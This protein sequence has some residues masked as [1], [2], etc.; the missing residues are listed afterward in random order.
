MNSQEYDETI[1]EIDDDV[2]D[3]VYAMIALVCEV[4][5]QQ[6]FFIDDHTDHEGLGEASSRLLD[7][8]K[9][10][11]VSVAS[12][13]SERSDLRLTTAAIVWNIIQAVS[14]TFSR[15]GLH[16]Q[17]EVISTNC[18]VVDELDPCLPNSAILET[19]TSVSKTKQDEDA[20]DFPQFLSH[21]PKS[22]FQGHE[23][24]TESLKET[25]LLSNHKLLS[26]SSSDNKFASLP[27]SGNEENLVPERLKETLPSVNQKPSSLRFNATES[28]YK[29]PSLSLSGN[30]DNLMLEH[31]TTNSF[32]N[33]SAVHEKA[34]QTSLKMR[35]VCENDLTIP[36]I[37]D[38]LLDIATSAKSPQPNHNF[39]QA[40]FV[41][42]DLLKMA[43]TIR[44]SCFENE[45]DVN[46]LFSGLSL[47][48]ILC[49]HENIFVKSIYDYFIGMGCKP[50]QAC[51]N[52][53][54]VYA[55]AACQGN[56]E[57]MKYIRDTHSNIWSSTL[58][59]SQNTDRNVLHCIMDYAI[60]SNYDSLFECL[61]PS[62]CSE[63]CKAIKG[64]IVP[65]LVMALK[66]GNYA[67]IQSISKQI[68]IWN[69][70]TANVADERT[71]LFM[72]MTSPHAHVC[73]LQMIP[74]ITSLESFV[75]QSNERPR[76]FAMMLQSY[77]M[78][79]RNI[80]FH[81]LKQQHVLYFMELDKVE[82]FIFHDK[83]TTRSGLIS[84]LSFLLE[85]HHSN[86]VVLWHC[87][88]LVIGLSHDEEMALDLL[89]IANIEAVKNHHHWRSFDRFTGES[90][91]HIAA[92]KGWTEILSCLYDLG[93]DINPFCFM[94]QT[95][96]HSCALHNSVK[97]IML[98]NKLGAEASIESGDGI[99]PI[100]CSLEA[101]N[102]ECSMEILNNVGCKKSLFRTDS[103]GLSPLMRALELKHLQVAHKI[104]KMFPE[105]ANFVSMSGTNI[106]HAAAPHLA[107]VQQLVSWSSQEGKDIW[108][109]L[110]QKNN[111]GE[112]PKD[113][114]AHCGYLDSLRFFMQI[115]QAK[116]S[117]NAVKSV[118]EMDVQYS[119]SKEAF[120]QVDFSSSVSVHRFLSNHSDSIDSYDFY[121]R[122]PIILAVQAKNLLGA[123]HLV[124][125]GADILKTDALGNSVM[126]Y[127]FLTNR[128]QSLWMW[129][130][131]TT[132]DTDPSD[133]LQCIIQRNSEDIVAKCLTLKNNAGITPFGLA[134]MNEFYI[135]VALLCG[136]AKFPKSLLNIQLPN[137]TY[138]LHVACSKN[139]VNLVVIFLNLGSNP[140]VFDSN[141]MSPEYIARSH[142]H[143][144]ITLI[145]MQFCNALKI[146]CAVRGYLCRVHALT[147]RAD[148]I[149]IQNV[150]FSIIEDTTSSM[151]QYSDLRV[152]FPRAN[153]N[154]LEHPKHPDIVP[155]AYAAMYDLIYVFQQFNLLVNVFLYSGV[156]TAKH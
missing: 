105:Q 103:K 147:N 95:P 85:K 18:I 70:T 8:L 76:E 54:N 56:F 68:Y 122:T 127:M 84:R 116:G 141:G 119:E 24:S 131:S 124:D 2:W 120:S 50:D 53:C 47:L 16:I 110:Q 128:E 11:D 142:G 100:A 94:M 108:A 64:D 146:Q 144:S 49:I 89:S 93:H 34:R 25:L 40:N 58:C 42:G 137:G 112:T 78:G 41:H 149:G 140:S 15:P 135:D 96:M 30:Q 145:L 32:S 36:V 154:A 107:S 87:I 10:Y 151:Q 38:F 148:C 77:Q 29:F 73:L 152:N 20:L 115:Y 12:S 21:Q 126:H 66:L 22:A 102:I 27:S 153:W 111:G 3:V 132:S 6:Y 143:N 7:D 72:M 91:L 37:T 4:N 130:E 55:F 35:F 113:I 71:F 121:H 5:G 48:H 90:A 75:V 28:E 82:P 44:F 86:T 31:T 117:V 13:D 123:Q 92:K 74:N 9:E 79:H 46:R 39:S 97:C 114:A 51:S 65:P 150:V 69:L 101:M 45:K 59:R 43:S 104:L 81:I 156:I 138:C 23:S 67:F 133:V 155:M 83:K 88:H 136:E 19:G 1:I 109:F 60:P 63:M 17:E 134:V 52:G 125:A 129:E 99:S 118:Q 80:V 26:S 98:L 33:N 14:E 139:L 61:G 106:F 57:A 62:V